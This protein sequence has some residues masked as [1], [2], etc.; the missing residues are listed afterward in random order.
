M[1]QVRLL[2]LDETSYWIIPDAYHSKIEQQ[3]VILKTAPEIA[4]HFVNY[5]RHASIQQMI[6]SAGYHVPT[7][8]N[9]GD[10]Q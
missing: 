7:F 1:S 10:P 3:L 4:D 8:A 9:H 5:L 2:A 6:S